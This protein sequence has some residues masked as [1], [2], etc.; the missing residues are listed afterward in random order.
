MPARDLRIEVL[1]S[2][3][4]LLATDPRGPSDDSD[5]G[6]PQ[7]VRGGVFGAGTK[8]RALRYLLKNSS[9]TQGRAPRLLDVGAQ[10]GAMA[11]YAARLGFRVAAVDYPHYARRFAPI[12]APHGVNYRSCDVSHE[13]L[14]FPDASF[15][16]VTYMDII[17]HHAFSPKRVLREIRRVLAPGGSVI[18]TTPNHASIYNRLSLFLGRSVQDDFAYFFDSC[19][20]YDTYPGHHRE[21]TRRDLRLAL[22]ATGFRV[23][24]CRV[25]E[26][27]LAAQVYGFRHTNGAP[28]GLRSYL[29]L[30]AAGAGTVWSTLHLPLG[31]LLWAVGEKPPTADEGAGRLT[32]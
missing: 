6:Y 26:D 16:F 24:E 15:D 31:R 25:F 19:D 27:D 9:L 21:Y 11:A 12:L 14:P 29:N 17:E 28:R 7:W 4:E 1:V 30:L 13:P 22:A 23:L 3:L 8:F 18:I 5:T 32:D 20:G 10:V 2:I